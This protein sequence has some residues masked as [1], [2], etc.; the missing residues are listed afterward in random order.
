MS[1]A[2]WS[3]HS[4]L[5]LLSALL[6]VRDAKHESLFSCIRAACGLEMTRA[7]LFIYFFA[8]FLIKV[9][10]LQKAKK[11]IFGR[12]AEADGKTTGGHRVSKDLLD[13]LDWLCF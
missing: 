9:S 11:M 6:W 5:E 10:L 3:S 4:F 1:G 7:H 8:T 13:L 12:R 2:G